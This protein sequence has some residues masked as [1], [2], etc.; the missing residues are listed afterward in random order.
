MLRYKDYYHTVTKTDHGLDIDVSKCNN[1]CNNHSYTACSKCDCK[2]RCFA[3]SFAKN[4]L[5]EFK[6]H[7]FTWKDIVQIDGK[8]YEEEF[9]ISGLMDD[10][11]TYQI[12]EFLEA[13]AK[14]YDVSPENIK[15]YVMDNIQPSPM[16]F[17]LAEDCG[18]YIDGTPEWYIS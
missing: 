15:T 9:Q 7:H 5:A 2:D 14:K 17:I 6:E 12:D 13:V 16:E 11:N 3:K 10:E 1:S 4:T 8:L 18:C